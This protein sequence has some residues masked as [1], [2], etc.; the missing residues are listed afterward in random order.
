MEGGTLD[1]GA[2]EERNDESGVLP[3][4]DTLLESS[5]L[6]PTT[7]GERKE[8]LL[9][10]ESDPSIAGCRRIASSINDR[11]NLNVQTL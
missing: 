1:G 5:P 4:D 9:V 2:G 10:S 7:L 8:T 11:G 6:C 3:T